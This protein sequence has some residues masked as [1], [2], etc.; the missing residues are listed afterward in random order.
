MTERTDRIDITYCAIDQMVA[1]HGQSKPKEF[2]N[3]VWDAKEEFEIYKKQVGDRYSPSQWIIITKYFK[4]IFKLK[5]KKE[6][7][8]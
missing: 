8:K 1:A 4:E 7:S 6:N 5:I 3:G 2:G